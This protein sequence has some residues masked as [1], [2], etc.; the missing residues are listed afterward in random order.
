[1]GMLLVYLQISFKKHFQICFQLI[2]ILVF[3]TSCTSTTELKPELETQQSL[4]I[5]YALSL[6]GKPYR[7][8]KESPEEGFDCS[9]FVMHVYGRHGINLPRTAREMAATLPIVPKR[10]VRSGDL[11]FFHTRSHKY[12]HVGIYLNDDRFIHAPNRRIGR[13]LVSRL[14]NSYWG[15]RFVG[16]RRPRLN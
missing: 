12:S 16:V 10:A 1:M 9:G 5:R 6:Q 2:L 4:L 8:G 3:V 7:W 11:V 13:V 15:K 14:N